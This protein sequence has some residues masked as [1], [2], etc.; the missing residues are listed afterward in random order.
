MLS[1]EELRNLSASR[2]QFEQQIQQLSQQVTQL[3]STIEQLQRVVMLLMKGPRRIKQGRNG[4][5]ALELLDE[6]GQVVSS[7]QIVRDSQGRMLG[8]Q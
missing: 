5:E 6:E 1:I 8:S 4:P 3:S 7:Q 2:E